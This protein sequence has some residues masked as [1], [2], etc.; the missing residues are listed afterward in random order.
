MA[1]ST[2]CWE[3][4]YGAADF[5]NAGS[6]CHGWSALPVYYYHANVLGFR[7]LTPG[8]KKFLISPYC[9]GFHEAEGEVATPAGKIR[10]E[11]H[12]NGSGIVL[13]ATGPKECKP[14]LVPS[15]GSEIVEAKYN[16]IEMI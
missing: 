1:G 3:T 12:K 9:D 6:L 10:V 5:N 16:D 7:P 15:T 4:Q 8:F 11:W 13:N 14:V 2:T